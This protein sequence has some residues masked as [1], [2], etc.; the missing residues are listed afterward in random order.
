MTN[1]TTVRVRYSETDQMGVVYHPHYLSWMEIGR[2][3]LLRD[4]GYRYR[5]LEEAGYLLP[6]VAVYARY[7]SP[8]LYDEDIV[9]ESAATELGGTKLRI[10]YRMRKPDGAPVCE[11]YTV[12]ALVLKKGMRPTRFPPDIRDALQRCLESSEWMVRPV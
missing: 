10:D 12:H 6:L 8:A 11:G 4:I 1:K 2:T 7:L 5:D 9:V 3:E